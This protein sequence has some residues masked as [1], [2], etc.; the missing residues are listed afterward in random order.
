MDDLKKDPA[1]MYSD[2]PICRYRWL[3]SLTNEELKELYDLMNRAKARAA[4]SK[5]TEE[6]LETES[7]DWQEFYEAL[8]AVMRERGLL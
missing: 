5:K 4:K 8:E 6:E 2:I 7:S 3:R 1:G